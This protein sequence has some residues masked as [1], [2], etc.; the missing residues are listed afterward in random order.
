M[1]SY[2]KERDFQK[3]RTYLVSQINASWILGFPLISTTSYE[4]RLST[5]Y[6]AHSGH[7]KLPVDM[8]QARQLSVPGVN[9]SLICIVAASQAHLL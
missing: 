1:S 3:G 7:Y 6:K 9:G 4:S 2:L 8:V 5:A